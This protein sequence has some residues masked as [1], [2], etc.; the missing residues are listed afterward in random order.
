LNIA[1]SSIRHNLGKRIE[2]RRIPEIIFK[3]DIVLDKGLSVLKL[4]E[5][6]KNKNEDKNDEDKDVNS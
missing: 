1:K 2:M 6:L 5:E 4:L 3:D